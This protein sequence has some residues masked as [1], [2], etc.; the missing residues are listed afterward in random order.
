MFGG[1]INKHMRFARNK[2]SGETDRQ[3]TGMQR[4][5][6]YLGTEAKRASWL[7]FIMNIF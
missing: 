3:R 1:L 2:V 7:V 4:K 6:Q 5:G